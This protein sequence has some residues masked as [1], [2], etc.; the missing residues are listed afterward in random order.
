MFPIKRIVAATDMSP[1]A[2]RAEARAAL[3]ARELRCESLHLL[4]VID[5]LA[6]EALRHLDP[7]PLDTEQRLMESSRTQ[8]AEIEH[9]L[10]DK[11]GIQ[12]ITTT[13][14]VGRAYTEIVHYAELLGVG[15]V[16][17]GAHGGGFVRDLFIGS[18]VDKVLRKLT[19]PLLI[20]K[21][22]P[23]VMYRNILVAVDFSESSR[24]AARFAMN[25]APH[26]HITVLH[27]FEVPFE[28]SLHSAGVDD[29]LMQIYEAEIKTRK[30]GE[31]QQFIAELGASSGLVSGIIERGHAHAVIRGKIESLA[32]DLIV[33]GKHGRSERD[34]M[35]PGGV[36]T[37]V[38]QDAGCDVLVIG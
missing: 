29:K 23:E 9:K 7:T 5:N 15:L 2:S 31:M 13:L 3:L 38:I 11:Y 34:E 1:F 27:A 18:T 25:I 21:R 19:R 14:N 28:A 33:V 32:P 10:S 8:L 26:A 12:V 20:V 35:L 16:V 24:Q 4:H 17:L 22:E 37:R 6:L 36:T 30:N